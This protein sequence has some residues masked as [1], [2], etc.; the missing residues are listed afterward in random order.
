MDLTALADFNLVAAHGG[1]GKASRASGRAK[2][3]LSRR[4]ME[5]EESLGIRLLERSARALR[6]TDAGRSLHERTEGLL[7]E[8][9]EIG[10]TLGAGTIQ[11]RGRLAISAPVLF[12]HIAMGRI[13]A[14]FTAAYP[15]VQL[16]ITAEDRQVDP[17][18]DGYDL[19]IRVN[20]Q[21]DAKLVGRCFVHD[22]M[23]LV[24]A[25]S[26][27]QPLA[28]RGTPPPA[29]PAVLL[30]QASPGTVWQIEDGGV[31]HVLL[32]E[33][34]V[35]ASSLLV[36]RDAALA[37]AG[38]AM[39]PV[40]MVGG[41]IAAG[42]LVKWGRIADHPIALWVLHSSRRLVSPKVSAFVD[43]ICAAFP[44]RYL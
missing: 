6:L 4:V 44:E 14:G 29:V 42:R 36:I 1:F 39:L 8:I 38:A 19:V 15:D 9:T 33:P 7:G 10:E 13:A 2:A 27:V 12:S 3:T 22:E 21:A 28:T 35:R 31:T 30:S 18:E 23:L 34:R 26:V 32:P 16:E 17:V 40:S 20:P 24:A 37:G 41:D 11:P 25:P 5:L 43:F